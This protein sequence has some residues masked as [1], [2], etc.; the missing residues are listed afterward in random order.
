MSCS[1]LRTMHRLTIFTD[2][3]VKLH[4]QQLQQHRQFLSSYWLDPIHADNSCTADHCMTRR[5]AIYR[6]EIDTCNC[7]VITPQSIES[8]GTLRVVCNRRTFS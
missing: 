2:S 1:A 3:G 5:R 4:Q 8:A 6:A 7:Y